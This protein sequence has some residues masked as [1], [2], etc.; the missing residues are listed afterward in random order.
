[1][2]YN[3]YMLPGLSRAGYRAKRLECVELAPAFR[4]PYALPQR[5]QAGR[6]PNASRS[7]LAA[8]LLCVFA[9]TVSRAY[10]QEWPQWGGTSARNMY[11][12]ATNLPDHF[13]KGKSGDIKF[14][15]ASEELDGSNLENF[16]WVAKLG[17]QSYG[18]V[19][20]AHGRVFIGTNNENPRDS[21]HVGDRSILL[22]LDQK[23]SDLLCQPPA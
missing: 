2:S 10:A 12:L 17:S 7:S 18:N 9:L 5:Q 4:P 6:T 21:R 8:L 23:T 20:V 16:K 19:T 11:C 3:S 14:K 1:M 22:C 15:G 13:T